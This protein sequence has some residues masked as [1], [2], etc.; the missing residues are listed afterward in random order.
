MH[1]AMSH[2][3]FFFKDAAP[4]APR[5]Q[6]HRFSF[7]HD[8]CRCRFVF[9]LIELLFSP[10]EAF[11]PLTGMPPLAGR[12]LTPEILSGFDI[13][14]PAAVAAAA[15]P[16]PPPAATLMVMPPPLLMAAFSM[17]PKIRRLL[18]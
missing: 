11:A 3:L 4:G 7:N 10:I 6:R 8:G 5:R 1:S 15:T 12:L 17:P 16:P 18:R 14:P 9:S 2:S 13:S